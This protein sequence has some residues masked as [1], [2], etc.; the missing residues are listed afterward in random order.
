[1]TTSVVIGSNR[2]IG[3]ELTKQFAARGDKVIATC[4]KTSPALANVEATVLE[5]I[6]VGDSSSLVKLKGAIGEKKIDTLLINAGI[7]RP[8]QLG[9]LNYETI[10][11]QL[12]INSL[13]PLRVVEALRESLGRGAKIGIVTSRMGSIADNGSGGAYGYRMSKAAVNAAGMSL[14]QDL[15]AEGISVVLLHPGYVRTD[16]TGGNGLIDADESA[17]GLIA[18]ISELTLETTGTFKHTNGE[19]LPW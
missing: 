17:R 5:G 9:T 16:M 1:M 7:M 4:R 6:D 13:G 12:N 18:R 15:K 8:S 19:S 11:E 10:I 2:G 14:A 3:L